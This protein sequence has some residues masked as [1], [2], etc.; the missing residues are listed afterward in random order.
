MRL[1][2]DTHF[3]IWLAR[4]PE[5]IRPAEAALLDDAEIFV[6]ALSIWEIRL[7]WIARHAIG[8][9]K[10]VLSPEDALAHVR[11]SGATMLALTPIQAGSMLQETLSHRDPFD[12]QLLIQAQTLDL[13]LLT[14][15]RLLAD[16]PLT[17]SV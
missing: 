12:E 3:V 4:S 13:R 8:V 16:H 1:L 15:D 5:E 7:K 2:L 6:S 11:Q 17:L 9:R 10:G 14:R